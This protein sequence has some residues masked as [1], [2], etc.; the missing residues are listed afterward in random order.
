[1][2]ASKFSVIGFLASE[3]GL[4]QAAR[5]VAN[6]IKSQ[7]IP[8]NL[9]NIYLEGRSNAT[10]FYKECEA[11][12]PGNTNI[13]ISGID[14]IH[15]LDSQLK[16]MGSG[17]KNYLYLFWELDKIPS[18]KLSE[19]NSFDEV[20]APTSFIANA[21][22]RAL[23]REIST[24][25]LPVPIPENYEPNRIRDGVLRIYAS[26]DFDSWVSRKNPQGV[27]DAFNAAFPKS[28]DDVRLIVKVRGENDGGFRDALESYRLNDHRIHIIDYTLPRDEIDVLIN[29]CNV[30]LSMH[31]SE[32][33]GLGPAEAL[34]REKIVVSTNYSGTVDFINSQT[35]FP[36]DFR[37]RAL[38]PQEYCYWENQSWAEPVIESAA[39]ALREIYENFDRALERAKFGRMLM[40]RNHSY[41]AAGRAFR[42]LL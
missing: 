20:I 38:E 31:R 4:G 8:I 24:I 27:L 22:S 19:L 9:V 11:Y 1:M 23:E 10:E 42:S 36:V 26:M 34:V 7:N 12:E 32:G 13:L 18:S 17:S 2:G 25:P 3:I 30:Y 15:G 21:V 41:G 5:N 39:S 28:F 29:D 40:L 37:L 6:A 35:G 14:G 16:Q 33:F